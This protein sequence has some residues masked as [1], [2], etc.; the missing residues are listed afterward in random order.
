VPTAIAFIRVDRAGTVRDLSALARVRELPSFWWEEVGQVGGAPPDLFTS[1]RYGRVGLRNAD[2][3]QLARDVAEF[4]RIERDI[5]V[6]GG[7]H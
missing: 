1:V 2:A 3:R 4:R 5:V 7:A 6:A